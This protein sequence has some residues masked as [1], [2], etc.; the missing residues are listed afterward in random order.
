MIQCMKMGGKEMNT[1]LFPIISPPF[2]WLSAE[3]FYSLPQ[4]LTRFRNEC[5]KDNLLI[6]LNKISVELW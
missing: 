5:N 1:N 6:S 4:I 3:N 2:L